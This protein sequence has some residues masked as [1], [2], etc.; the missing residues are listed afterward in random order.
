MAGRAM[1]RDDGAQDL[2]RRLRRRV[3]ALAAPGTLWLVLFFVLP[4]VI[5][6]IYS[7]QQRSA[8]GDIAWTWTLAN[9]RELFASSNTATYLGVFW[10]SLWLAVVTTA[11]CLLVSYPLAYYIAR[12]SARWRAALI[13]AMMIPFWTNFLVRITPGSFCST[14]PA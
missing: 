3:A 10:R 6:V 11:L 14:T 12:Q 2:R 5:I 1:A 13:F 4:L 7:F 8:T 9:Y